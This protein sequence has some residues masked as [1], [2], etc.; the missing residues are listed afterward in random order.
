MRFAAAV[1][2]L[3]AALAQP[4]VH[5]EGMSDPLTLLGR[6]A[7]AGQKLSYVGT[8]TYQS[9]GASETSR[10]AH[11]MDATGEYE[12]LEVLDGSPREVIRS[13]NE[14]RCVL[15]EQKTVII[16]QAGGR[17]AFPARLPASFSNLAENYRI[18]K[19]ELGRVA[20][21]EAQSVVLEPRDDLRFGY[22]LWADVQSGLLLKSRMVDES[23]DTIEQFAFSD[24]RI[25][26]DVGADLLRSRFDQSGGWRVINAR[27]SEISRS[28]GGWVLRSPLPGYSLMSVMRR[29]L[30][31]ERGEAI[32]MVYSDGLAAIS[33]FI[34]P[35]AAQG[36]S[37]AMGPL[38]SGAINIY[39]RTVDRHLVT[40]LGEV[41]ARAVQRLADGI[42]HSVQ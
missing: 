3:C 28:E 10:I 21:Y 23:G 1:I 32:H 14:V 13:G 36:A 16:D 25:G 15:P 2:A 7:N 29:P 6:I 27:G 12:R 26:G 30:G 41:P 33:V 22:V 37:P 11:R 42:E 5:A 34:E 38:S 9:R 8:F 39:K 24:V 31:R 18:R 20:G 35:L 40:V 19:G 17:R 4:T